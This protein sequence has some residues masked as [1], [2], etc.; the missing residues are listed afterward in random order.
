M[1]GDFGTTLPVPLQNASHLHSPEMQEGRVLVLNPWCLGMPVLKWL[2]PTTDNRS[3]AVQLNKYAI[4]SKVG[5][6]D[7]RMRLFFCKVTEQVQQRVGVCKNL[8]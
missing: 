7:A 3:K 2:L 8:R 5:Q 4:L 1:T 6:L